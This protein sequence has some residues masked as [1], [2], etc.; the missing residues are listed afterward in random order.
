MAS[1]A[2]A[3]EPTDDGTPVDQLTFEAAVAEL[4][5]IVEHIESGE[6]PL[7]ASMTR[8]RRGRALLQRCRAILKIAE[9]ELEQ[10]AVEDLPD[11]DRDDA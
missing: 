1:T 10:T 7:E 6:L 9:Q 2:D 11:T 3:S 4:E 5:S 8:H